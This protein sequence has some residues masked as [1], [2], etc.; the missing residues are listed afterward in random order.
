MLKSRIGRI[1]VI[2][3]FLGLG[4][5]LILQAGSPAPE[6]VTRIEAVQALA[7]GAQRGDTP[8]DRPS[9]TGATS[10]V[11]GEPVAPVVVNMKDV[12]AGPADVD[13]IKELYEK[14][15]IDLYENDGPISDG[16]FQAMVA[17]SERQPVDDSVQ[18][19]IPQLGVLNSGVNFKAIDYTQSMQG[20]PP[21]PDIMVG[22]DHI[23]VGVNTSFQV[24]DKNGNS[25]VGPTLY[26]SFWGSNCGTGSNVVMFDPYSVYDEEANR[27]VMG[28]TAYDPNVNGGDNGYACIAV[29]QTDSATGS[30][31]LYSF[32]GN[33]GGGSDYFFDYPHIGVGQDALYLGANM[34][35]SSFVRNHI[36]AFDKDAMYAG[37]SANSVKFDVGTANFTLQPAKLKGFT[38]GGWPT[39]AN[40]PHY[41]VDAQYGNN[42]NRLTVWKFSDPWGSPSFTQAGTVTVSSYSLP[43]S[44]PQQGGSNIQ[45]NDNR[46]LD[47]EYWGGKLWTTHTVGCNPGGGTVNCIRWYE[48]DISS[49][50]PSLVQQGTLSSSSTYRS[51]PDLGVNSCGDMLVGYTMTSSSMY[52]SVYVAGREAGDASGTL[53]DETLLKAG[54]DF[55]T[56]YDSVPRRWGDYTGLAL[57]PDGETFWYLGEYSRPQTTARWSTWVGSFTWS[58]C[59]VGPTPTPG[60]TATPTNTPEPTATP[61]PQTCTTYTASDTPIALPNGTSSISSNIAVS[62]SGSILDV[63]VDVDMAHVYVG[64]LGF[65]LTH[66]DTSNAVTIIDRPGVPASTYGCSGDDI[67]ATLDDGA[68]SPVENEC[69]GSIPTINGTFSPNNALAA[70]NGENGNGTWTLTVEDFY[71]SADA[72][73]L[74]GWSVE[75]CVEDNGSPTPTPTNTPVPPTPTNT[76]VPPTPTNT[77]IPPTPTNT[78]IPPTPT[79]TPVPPTPTPA[80]DGLFCS[81]PGI[82]IPDP[83]STSDSQSVSDTRT[84]NDLNVI[85]DASHT[86]VG[87]LTFTLTHND[88]GTS[89]TIFDRPGVPGSTYGCSGNDIAATLDD[90]AGSPVEGQC[91]AG[92]P[93]INGTFSPNNALSAFDGENM[94]GSWTLSVSDAVGADSG[95]LNSWCLEAT[96][97][98]PSPTDTPVPPT[99]TP[100]P[101]A[102]NTPVPTATNTPAP[103]ATNTPAPTATNTPVPTPT[104]T[105]TPGGSDKIYVS[106]STGGSIDGISFQ[107]EDILLYDTGTGSWSMYFDGSDVLPSTD[108]NAFALLADGTILMSFNNAPNVSGVGIVDDSDIVQFT[109]TSLGSTTAGTFVMFFDGSDVGLT[110]SGEDISS[111]AVSPAGNLVVSFLGSWSVTGASGVDEDLAEFAATSWGTSTSGTWSMYFDGS[112]VGLNTSSNEDVWGAY[113][114]TNGNIYLTTQG[115][116]G[117]AGLSGDGSDIF[118]CNSPTTGSVT[119]CSSFTMYFDGSAEGIGSEQ[120][121][122]IVI[123]Q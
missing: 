10:Y 98:G 2:L 14:G 117:V 37:N 36:F 69:A 87:D 75:I 33:P 116:F 100:A 91:D 79:N 44:Q 5:W 20:V 52:P 67:L 38:T 83:G 93:T 105:P 13:I 62:G 24:F 49:G 3:L 64:D 43:V 21:D 25:L 47:V 92:T 85:L 39:N 6:T 1:L 41:F 28:I 63:N 104:N 30:W 46:L 88:S 113:I 42:Q 32:D 82:S 90:E 4:T 77:P 8:V 9:L 50:S 40:E 120:I 70:F 115:A 51:F 45:G 12:P 108:I 57:D 18:S 72:G 99:S 58:D 66:Q 11:Y 48:I 71:T 17:E 97:G 29:S 86:W 81:N 76:P 55:Y 22:N 94:N 114:A 68:S 80:P 59:T 109:P 107:D 89:V 31:H 34:F 19:D 110:T 121:D 35:G 101:T 95:T 119:S 123:V 23:V 118:I 96:L 15:E 7:P 103:T 122:G 65:T 60:P 61:L 53:K 106:S 102:T 27:Y 111:I 56:A 73:T 54:E 78:P 112:D 74:N 84:I 26:S 16:A